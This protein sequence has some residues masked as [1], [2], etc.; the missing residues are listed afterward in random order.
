L[1]CDEE[2]SGDVHLDVGRIAHVETTLPS[3]DTFRPARRPL[4]TW[5]MRSLSYAQIV[6]L[7]PRSVFA[8]PY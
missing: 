6:Q 7:T 2:L 5:L 8:S 1:Q 3:S 4:M